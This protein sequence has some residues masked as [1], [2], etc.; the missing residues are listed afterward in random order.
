MKNSDIIENNYYIIQKEINGE[1]KR[2]YAKIDRKFNYNGNILYEYTY[3]YYNYHEGYCNISNIK[4][5]T[6]EEKIHAD[7]NHFWLLPQ[8][9]YQSA[10]P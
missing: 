2:Q 9:F 10:P 6:S 8:Q 4:E 3:G 7:N 1:I 5:L